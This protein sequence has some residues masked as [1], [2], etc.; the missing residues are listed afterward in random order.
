MS[1]ELI[2]TNE[3]TNENL[4]SQEAMISQFIRELNLIYHDYQRRINIE[5]WKS[6]FTSDLFSHIRLENNFYSSVCDYLCKN[7]ALPHEIWLFI[8]ESLSLLGWIKSRRSDYLYRYIPLMI[9]IG[10]ELNYDFS[11]FEGLSNDQINSF[12]SLREKAYYALTCGYVSNAEY[13]I[14]DALKIKPNDNEIKKLAIIYCLRE[15]NLIRAAKTYYSLTRQEVIYFD[16]LKKIKDYITACD[17]LIQNKDNSKLI[18]GI[19][20]NMLL[21]IINLDDDKDKT[22]DVHQELIEYLFKENVWHQSTI[23]FDMINSL[24]SLDKEH[25]FFGYIDKIVQTEKKNDEAI[26]KEVESIFGFVD[27]ANILQFYDKKLEFNPHCAD[28]WNRKGDMLSSLGEFEKAIACYDKAIEIEPESVWGYHNKACALESLGQTDESVRFFAS[29]SL[30]YLD[31]FKKTGKLPYAHIF[32]TSYAHIL[33]YDK[34]YITVLQYLD[35][36][37]EIEPKKAY[38]WNQKGECLSEMEKYEEAIQ[39]FEKAYTYKLGKGYIYL[40]NKGQALANL[41]Q[42]EEAIKCYDQILESE[43]TYHRAWYYRAR[44]YEKQKDYL[45]AIS[46]YEKSILYCED[47]FGYI[48]DMGVALR[49]LGRYDEAIK[50]FDKVKELMPLFNKRMCYLKATVFY[51]SG[52]YDKALSHVHDLL[53]ADA[54][55]EDAQQL[56]EKI[57]E[58][59]TQ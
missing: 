4:P 15:F 57:L 18:K 45:N 26:L 6:L 46:N 54:D 32:L 39:C 36:A 2:E 30:K 52:E 33:I 21:K 35:K 25:L 11:H 34:Y 59:M 13:H 20:T 47:N 50:C 28:T 9:E 7:N 40:C 41:L 8:E 38:I 23:I 43:I 55:H 10:N 14:I 42:Y 16:V 44:A 37:L 3:Q 48:E 49:E 27:N 22:G 58:K 53:D 24:A 1:E 31:L 56:K 19:H 12:A 5:E 51:E 17:R 29:A